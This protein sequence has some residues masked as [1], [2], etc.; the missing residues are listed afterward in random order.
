MTNRGRSDSGV[1]FVL[2][3]TV[4]LGLLVLAAPFLTVAVND[5]AMSGGVIAEA[6]VEI[7]ARQQ[8]AYAAWWLEQ[9]TDGRRS[10]DR[11]GYHVEGDFVV[12]RDFV[13]DRGALIL[14]DGGHPLLSRKDP[15]GETWDLTVR[16]EQSLPNLWSA[17]PFIIAASLGRTVLTGEDVKPDDVEINLE[18]ASAF[19][20]K[21]G[22][23]WC[24]GERITYATR[25]GNRL[26]N[27]SRGADGG[28]RARKHKVETYV[29]DDRAR[30]ISMLP[31]MSPRA[32]GG[33][34]E[35]ADPAA[36]KEITLYGDGVLTPIEVDRLARE[37]TVDSWR[38]T[39]QPF[40]PG[41]TL[42][43][44]IDLET[45]LDTTDG[46]KIRVK[47]NDG[48]NAGTLV[49]IT[50]GTNVD[51]A[52]VVASQRGGNSATLTLA[53]PPKNNYA[54]LRTWV[55]PMVRHPVN[56]NTASKATLK[57]VITGLQITGGR[58]DVG[59]QG[60]VTVGAAELV[61]DR[62]LGARPIKDIQQ[63]RDLLQETSE[64]SLGVFDQMQMIAVFRNAIDANDWTL[65]S[66][67]V[68]FCFKSYDY[69]TITASATVNDPAGT[70]RARRR[71]TQRVR[72]AA[73]GEQV[74]RIDTQEDFESPIVRARDSYY[75]TTYPNPVERVNP[76]SQNEIPASRIPRMLLGST[77]SRN[78]P[79]NQDKASSDSA[80]GV[81]PHKAEGDVRLSPARME[82]LFGFQQHMDGQAFQMPDNVAVE[83][84]DPDGWKLEKGPYQI[85]LRDNG[86]RNPSNRAGRGGGGGGGGQF[87]PGGGGRGG[88]RGGG[89][90]GG[91]SGALLGRTGVNPLKVDMWMRLE[92]VGGQATFFDLMGS[93]PDQRITFNATGTGEIKVRVRDRT[94]QKPGGVEEACETIF[95]PPAGLWKQH[96][97]YHA[98]ASWRGCKP[99]EVSVWW[100]GMKRGEAKYS[101]TL[102]GSMSDSDTTF[103]VERADDWPT[104]G[105]CWVGREAI[106]FTRSGTSF[107][108]VQYPTVNY[109]AQGGTVAG[110]NGRG[111]RGTPA[112][113][114]AAGEPVQVFGYSSL[115]RSQTGTGGI[116]IPRGGGNLGSTL[117]PWMFASFAGNDVRIVPPTQTTPQLTFEVLDPAKPNG[118]RLQLL[119]AAGMAA[120]FA[121][122]FQASGGYVL[123]V[124]MLPMTNVP[125]G[126]GGN[127]T[128][129]AE[130]ATYQSFAGGYLNG[131]QPVASPP[132]PDLASATQLGN[133]PF[134]SQRQIHY[135]RLTQPPTPYFCAVFPISVHL[136]SVD[137]YLTPRANQGQSQVNQE[138]VSLGVPD[139]DD[140]ETAH[141]IEWIGYYHVD[142]AKKMLLCD[143]ANRLELT[144]R[145]V[146]GLLL[147][148]APGGGGNNQGGAPLPPPIISRDSLGMRGRHGTDIF[149]YSKVDTGQQT[150]ETSEDVTPVFRVIQFPGIGFLPPTQPNTPPPPVPGHPAPG[151]G[152]SVTLEAANASV[153]KRFDVTWSK[154]GLA[155]VGES[156]GQDFSQRAIPA[157]AEDNRDQYLRLLKFP[158]GELP[159]IA[160][161]AKARAGGDVDGTATEG[162]LDEIRVAP[163]QADRFIVWDHAAMGLNASQVTSSSSTTL[164]IDGISETA[165]EIPVAN[166]RWY[167]NAFQNL[168][169]GTGGGGGQG[170]PY[171]AILPDG[172]GIEFD[173]ELSGFPNNDAALVQIDDEV[174][175]FRRIGRTG[176]GA[177]AILDCE[178]GVMGTTPQRH[179]YGAN[180]VFL[181]FVPT[182][183]LSQAMNPT[184]SLIDIA[185]Q[186]GF[187]TTGGLL[188]INRELV[189]YSEI[190]G[191]QF[192][193]PPII[194][195]KGEEVGGLFRGRFGTT[196]SRHDNESIVIDMPF[197][198]WDRFA[199]SQD[200][201]EI[202]FYQCA[203]N[204]PGAWFEKFG[205]EEFRPSSNVQ[206]VTLVRLEP[207]VPWS[208][209]PSRA[210]PSLFRFESGLEQ[211][212][213]LHPIRRH[214]ST[215]EARFYVRYLSNSFDPV[216]LTMHDWKTSPEL[217]W[218]EVRY[219]DETQVLHRES[220]R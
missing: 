162:R 99:E 60:R 192:A 55:S 167:L 158:S 32:K 67:T 127:I 147:T 92:S 48:I 218:A 129:Q 24:D 153:R 109:G 16:D 216:T 36:V 133:F 130:L 72:V 69:F 124:G 206:I 63:L 75:T 41:Q 64:A 97:W 181:D 174:I 83:N 212:K 8:L 71:I 81:F 10:G 68:P 144:I 180:V 187:A 26:L 210:S 21:N 141:K 118:D 4:L 80:Q 142:T 177:P 195:E 101:T 164:Q 114:H 79:N 205:Y 214:G 179:G 154:N 31:F 173:A 146:I 150:H 196:P 171:L 93:D 12:P 96:T 172:R 175:A 148:G 208:T 132:N 106:E 15:R 137:G 209:D 156:P 38:V 44:P 160:Q 143:D 169:G 140:I 39:G 5:E 58:R 17:P 126:A 220:D 115:V 78:D 145:N 155:S 161:G 105:V 121:N 52:F 19:P 51:Y 200:N 20:L 134:F 203:V 170:A 76:W 100:D 201:P 94:I 217:R 131:I 29:I 61:V 112:C 116:A 128:F 88:R 185:S 9:Q 1:A 178:R 3:L 42:R 35:P 166:A 34:R 186:Q 103:S 157:F 73:P 50:D 107:Q 11:A 102:S 14:G 110:G 163:F 2:V 184:Q 139:Y 47:S 77:L 95:K 6:Q 66:S 188:L 219:L 85:P 98:G 90:G 202:S 56:I 40:G 70:E 211:D 104:H 213:S 82:G 151:W 54:E 183:M 123:I 138:F 111:R 18:D 197:R 189:H 57:R 91:N 122:S 190:R 176:K 7:G 37:F 89:G 53:A 199:E 194:D 22:A 30:E 62:I 28:G 207:D 168:P 49:R 159:R 23:I 117:G 204:R 86:S 119:P 87:G 25:E 149:G 108:V 46:F 125:G 74:V 13:G 182:T 84:I 191:R 43:A 165:T 45:Q 136:T 198:Y 215:L 59:K 135:L 152:D 27:C 113:P 65:G 193:M 120:S 33:W